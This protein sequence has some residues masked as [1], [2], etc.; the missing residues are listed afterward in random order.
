MKILWISYINSWTPTLLNAIKKYVEIAVI[1]PAG[2]Y[3]QLKKED[4]GVTYYSLHLT[5]KEM[6]RTMN[7]D[8]FHKYTC[9][10]N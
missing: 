3:E 2:G 5:A 9:W 10:R 7:R 1:I 4:D 6:K 8:T